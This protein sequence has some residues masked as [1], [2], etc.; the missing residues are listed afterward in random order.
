MLKRGHGKTDMVGAEYRKT[1]AHG[2]PVNSA[3]PQKEWKN[4]NGM[5]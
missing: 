4:N 2:K 3:P 1:I 5:L